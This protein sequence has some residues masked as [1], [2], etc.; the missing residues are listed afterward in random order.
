MG[1]T[2]KE[3]EARRLALDQL[4]ALMRAQRQTQDNTEAGWRLWYEQIGSKTIG[5]A[6]PK[7]RDMVYE[8][9]E[10]PERK[11][12]GPNPELHAEPGVLANCPYCNPKMVKKRRL[13]EVA[14]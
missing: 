9:Y 8:E 5:P 3:A 7:A 12:F 10:E 14:G 6:P 2:R 13:I 4:E 11:E 1:F